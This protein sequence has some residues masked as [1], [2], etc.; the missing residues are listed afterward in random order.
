VGGRSP[1]VIGK[2]TE[3]PVS[4]T[5]SV[6]KASCAMTKRDG[7]RLG[8]FSSVRKPWRGPLPAR[9]SSPLLSLGDV[10][11]RDCRV[12]GS[13]QN[14]RLKDVL[15]SPET[16]KVAMPPAALAER[17]DPDTVFQILETC[18]PCGPTLRGS[19]RVQV[20]KHGT[21]MCTAALASLFTRGGK[22]KGFSPRRRSRSPH[23]AIARFRSLLPG[24]GES[25]P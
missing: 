8:L 21:F 7:R 22:P 11:V 9:R 3:V 23:T 10:R 17:S 12:G 15:V 4:S 13:D 2:R 5:P 20:G 16:G 19:R 1:A 14:G 25:D 6:R 18:G 24:C